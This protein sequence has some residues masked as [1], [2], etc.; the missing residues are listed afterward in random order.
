MRARLLGMVRCIAGCALIFLAI[1]L[2]GLAAAPKAWSANPEPAADAPLCWPAADLRARADEER[3]RRGPAAFIAP[4]AGTPAP[5]TSVPPA[6]RRVIRRVNLPAGKKLVALTF[7]LCEQPHEIAGYQGRIVDYLRANDI[8]A[9]FFL[10]GKWILSHPHRSQQLMSDG[11]FEVANHSWEHRNFRLLHGAALVNE[12]RHTQVAY[13][14]TRQGLVARQCRVPD[15]RASPA[16]IAPER[17]SLFRFPFGACNEAALQTAGE[18]GLKVVQWDVSSGDPSHGM[19]RGAMAATV[20]ASARPGSIV[21]FHANGRGWHTPDALPAI[22]RGF[23][24]RGYG[25]V[26]VSE[27]LAAGEPVYSSTCYDSRPGDTDRYDHFAR[28]LEG[29]YRHAR[30]QPLPEKSN[31]PS[32]RPRPSRRIRQ[33]PDDQ[34]S[35]SGAR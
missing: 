27:L 32:Q 15:G 22:V 4:P 30:G 6:E 17:L 26:T 31:P 13:E 11:R 25:F 28:Y 12:F 20:L 9:T 7:D 24:E 23:R 29:I 2:V 18:M 35:G 5:F 3:I 19:G 33:R 34:R 8:K 10:G 1:F 16:E 21:L 14:Q